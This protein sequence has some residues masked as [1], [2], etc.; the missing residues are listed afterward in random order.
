MLASQLIDIIS[1]S[2]FVYLN[3]DVFAICLNSHL[4]ELEIILKYKVF[5][6]KIG[7]RYFI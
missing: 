1:V 3:E 4:A 6:I 2:E 7:N 5:N